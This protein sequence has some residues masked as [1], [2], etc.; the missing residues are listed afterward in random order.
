VIESLKVV[1]V[2]VEVIDS[3]GRSDRIAQGGGSRGSAQGGVH[4]GTDAHARP[5][6]SQVLLWGYVAETSN[7]SVRALKVDASYDA[8]AASEITESGQGDLD[9]VNLSDGLVVD[10]YHDFLIDHLGKDIHVLLNQTVR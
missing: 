10:G 7:L 5:A 6:A 1:A 4:R 3:R 9:G 2:G 8:V